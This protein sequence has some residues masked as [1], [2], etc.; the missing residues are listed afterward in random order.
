MTALERDGVNHLASAYPEPRPYLWLNPWFGGIHPYLGWFMNQWF[1]KEQFTGEP[2]E[3]TGKYGIVWRGV[4][5]A[6]DIQHKDDRWLRLEVEYLTLGG[7]NVLAIVHRLINRTDAPQG[8]SAGVVLW[9]EVGGA[10]TNNVLH[11]TQRRPCYEQAASTDDQIRVLC[12]RRRSEYGFEPSTERWGAV[13]NP[14]TGH[15][16]AVIVSHPNIRMDIATESM[17]AATL[18]WVGGG[19]GLEPEETKEFVSWLV[20]TDSVAKAQDYRALGEICEL[21]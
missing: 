20:L 11:Y 21:P 9:L 1:L 10:T 3:R 15:V 4:K 2:V 13:E 6:S 19:T 12:H 14:E 18:L 7:S 5:V 8:T 17:D 16:L